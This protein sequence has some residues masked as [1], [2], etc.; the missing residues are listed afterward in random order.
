VTCYYHVAAG[1]VKGT[2]RILWD[3][4]TGDSDIT[5]KYATG[6]RVIDSP[7]TS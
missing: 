2:H 7:P 1:V 5:E 6:F 3:R 4:E